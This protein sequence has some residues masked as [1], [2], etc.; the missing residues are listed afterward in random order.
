MSS[1]LIRDGILIISGTR[2][3]GGCPIISGTQVAADTRSYRISELRRI[4]DKFAYLK[5]AG[6]RSYIEYSSFSWYLIISGDDGY[7]NLSVTR[8]SLVANIFIGKF[9]IGRV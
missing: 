5:S 9:N 1:T 6:I 7:P 4:P 2:N 8:I 3:C